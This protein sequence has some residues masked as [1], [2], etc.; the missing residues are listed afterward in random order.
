MNDFKSVMQGLFKVAEA[1]KEWAATI[2]WKSVDE[3]MEYLSNELPK[4]LEK[5]SVKLMNRGWFIWFI[6]GTMPDFSE[7][8]ML[9]LA[10]MTRSKMHICGS[11]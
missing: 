10:K 5:E 4:D 1:F 7:K 9:L 8:C 2:D 6:D 11:I 3:G